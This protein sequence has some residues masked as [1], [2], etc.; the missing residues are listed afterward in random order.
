MV[1]VPRPVIS[2]SNI[3][4]VALKPLVNAT[5]KPEIVHAIIAALADVKRAYILFKPKKNGNTIKIVPR[6]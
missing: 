2:I 3:F 6:R 4:L 1:A 5:I